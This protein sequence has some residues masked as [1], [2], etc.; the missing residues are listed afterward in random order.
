MKI[1]VTGSSGRIGSTLVAKLLACGH[2]V[3]GI[4]LRTSGNS[5]SQF[6][7]FIVS[8]EDPKM[9][10][11]A[12]SNVEVV[13]HLGALMSW[14]ATEQDQMFKS[15]VAG[16]QILLQAAATA[17]VKRVVFASSGEVYP[18][19]KPSFLPITEKHPTLANSFYGVTKLLGE[20][21]VKF[22]QRA[23]S[24]E[25]VILRF[26]HTQDAGEL[27]DEGSFFSGPRFF[28]RPRIQQQI[29]FGNHAL[30]GI[31]QAVDPGEPA[32][33]LAY[34]ENGRP[35][36]MH[37]TDTR[38][39][40]SGLLL[41]AKHPNAAGEIFNLGSTDPVDFERLLKKMSAIT[42]YPIIQVTLPGSGVYY[43]TSNEKIRTKLGFTPQW[44][45]EQMLPEAAESRK[46]CVA[47]NN[48]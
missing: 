23:G 35:F 22:H 32:H 21:L 18:E 30:V 13:L 1:L 40:L 44:T 9:V 20:E 34:N 17:Q 2:Q 3:C 7:E 48:E 8:L 4:D 12:L 42:G 37:I 47:K 39:M 45:I 10:I 38:D 5:H 29:N 16:T 26:S 41:A 33:I 46:K 14:S 43:H 25:T 27:L 36:Q 31:L 19:N 28:L 6:E 24:F 15:N 11:T